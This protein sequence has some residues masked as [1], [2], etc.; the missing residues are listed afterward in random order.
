VTRFIAP[1]TLETACGNPVA[2]DMFGRDN[3]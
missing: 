1:L 2:V 3:R